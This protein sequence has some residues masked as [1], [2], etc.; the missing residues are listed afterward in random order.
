[1]S[2]CVA[3]IE[4]Y[5]EDAKKYGDHA[6]IIGRVVAVD[7]DEDYVDEEGRLKVDLVRPPLHVADNI[8]AFPYVTKRV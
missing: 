2:E 3:S 4:C 6:L 7:V 1:L 8:F 5:L